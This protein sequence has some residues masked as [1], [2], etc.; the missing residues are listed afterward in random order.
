MQSPYYILIEEVF[1]RFDKNSSEDI[2]ELLIANRGREKELIHNLFIKYSANPVEFDF[3]QNYF[4]EN[5]KEFLSAF[6][7]KYN[8]GKLNEIDNLLVKFKEKKAFFLNQLCTRYDL[9]VGSLID[10]IDFKTIESTNNFNIEKAEENKPEPVNTNISSDKNHSF[11]NRKR[12]IVI[13]A[14]SVLLLILLA[15]ILYKQVYI[16]WKIE[17]DA[18]RLYVFPGNLNLRN[19]ESSV[20]AGNVI[21]QI[22]YGTEVV[23]Y[24]MDSSWANVRVGEYK[25]FMGN[26]YKYLVDK[27]T[28]YRC[29]A[30]FG[31]NEARELII[32]SYLKRALLE[33]FLNNN[34]YGVMSNEALTRFPELKNTGKEEWQV[35]AFGKEVKFNSLAAGK[36]TGT[37]TSC[38]ALTITSRKTNQKRLLIFQF[39]SKE[40]AKLIFSGDFPLG[41][42]GI[43]VNTKRKV[44]ILVN[45]RA[46]PFQLLTHSILFGSN[47]AFSQNRQKIL[48]FNGGGFIY[49]DLAE[50]I[51]K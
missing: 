43:A 17:K 5:S 1:Q 15:I 27:K 11:I 39:D 37:D 36:L 45:D 26:P 6:Y 4:N 8:P 22:T 19:S 38:Y 13:I 31:N 40:I 20:S 35:F 10:F 42:D 7:Q 24:S 50:N 21:K 9:E 46:K 32:A 30:L 23:V 49:A 47:N 16:P 18:S 29:D 41:Y 51:I 3:F 28:F 48:Y 33:Y 25:G 14:G 44:K 34:Y 12:F 2:Y